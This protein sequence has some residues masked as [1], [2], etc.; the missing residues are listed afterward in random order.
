[1]PSA[2]KLIPDATPLP[3]I[4]EKITI[5]KVDRR[6]MITSNVK[7]EEL[8]SEMVDLPTYMQKVAASKKQ[9]LDRQLK[10]DK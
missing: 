9:L 7:K 8:H 3:P 1:L 2:T 5:Y 10:L 4:N 6:K